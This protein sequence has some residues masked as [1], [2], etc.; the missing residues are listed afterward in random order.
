MW[1]LLARL[2]VWLRSEEAEP[3][4]KDVLN[5]FLRVVGPQHPFSVSAAE[6]LSNVLRALH[7]S[8]E[9]DKVLKQFGLKTPL[10]GVSE[11]EEEE[12]GRGH[13]GKASASNGHTGNGHGNGKNASPKASPKT[14]PQKKKEKVAIEDVPD[15]D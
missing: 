7:K 12:G 15:V 8:D 10:Q 13:E 5:G 6:N 4:V 14:S 1:P 11:E 2:D 3:L 9:A